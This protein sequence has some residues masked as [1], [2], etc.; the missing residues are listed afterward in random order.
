[1]VVFS[2][3]TAQVPPTRQRDVTIVIGP[4]HDAQ[5]IRKEAAK[6]QGKYEL[7]IADCGLRNEIPALVLEFHPERN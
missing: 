7:R 1:M 5:I 3:S 4:Q 2:D 6:G